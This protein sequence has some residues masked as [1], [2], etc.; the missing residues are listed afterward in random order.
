MTS[1]PQGLALPKARA[2]ATSTSA[3]SVA[4][5][6]DFA[7]LRFWVMSRVCHFQDFE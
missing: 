2:R 6:F 4:S 7:Y 1:P 5:A 3:A